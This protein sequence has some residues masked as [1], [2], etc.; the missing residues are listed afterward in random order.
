MRETNAT[1]LNWIQL[2]S[3]LY[4]R[5]SYGQ[6]Q[7]AHA[8]L[9]KDVDLREIVRQVFSAN[10]LSA[11]CLQDHMGLMARVIERDNWESIGARAAVSTAVELAELLFTNV[12][13]FST[14]EGI[15][16]AVVGIVFCSVDLYRWSKGEISDTYLA[17]RL[18]EHT[19]GCAA[20]FGGA[21]VGG[22]VAVAIGA[23]SGGILAL[24]G[25]IVGGFVGD[26]VARY[27]VRWGY[28]TYIS[29]SAEERLKEYTTMVARAGVI[30]N[31]NIQ[32]HTLK[33]ANSRYRKKALLCHPDKFAN[34]PPKVRQQKEEEFKDLF[35][36]WQLVRQYYADNPGI[37]DDGDVT[38]EYHEGFV[39]VWV[40]R[41]RETVDDAWKFLRAFYEDAIHD[42][43][44][45]ANHTDLRQIEKIVMY[46]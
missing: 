20:A 34:E 8:E 29:M 35:G 45:P 43:Q 28:N 37:N 19:L 26:F 5:L 13:T 30:C 16:N 12:S 2:R 41:V 18:T 17:F 32:E 21:V 23:A 44:D 33:E 46:V 42:I 7:I 11:S 24:V 25:V 4:Q 14:G 1:T 31:V 40:L 39:E 15:S 27:I 38:E 22:A 3:L 10:E 36:A 6:I 9:I